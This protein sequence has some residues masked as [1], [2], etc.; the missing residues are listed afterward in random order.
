MAIHNFKTLLES[1]NKKTTL[2]EGEFYGVPGVEFIW[3]GEWS[4]PEVKYKDHLFNYYELENVL[5]DE[6]KEEYPEAREEDFDKYVLENK[7]RVYELLDDMLA[8]SGIEEAISHCLNAHKLKDE[9]SVTL[10]EDTTD[11][12]VP[13]F[14]GCYETP[15]QN[16]VNHL[17]D[18]GKI[19]VD[20][21]NEAVQEKLPSLSY[22]FEKVVSPKAYNFST[23]E[24]Y[25]K[26][27]FDLDEIINFLKNSEDF[28]Q[29]C[30]DNFSSY[31]GFMS[32]VPN[33]AS[34]FINELENGDNGKKNQC[35]QGVVQFII[36]PI[37][38]ELR[39]KLYDEVMGNV[40]EDLVA[41]VLERLEGGEE[42]Y[43]TGNGTSFELNKA[44][45][46]Y[47]EAQA[48]NALK[49]A[50]EKE[51]SHNWE[52]RWLTE[53]DLEDYDPQWFN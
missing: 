7:A 46:S 29:Y 33:S 25:A 12:I 21:V 23:D 34:E 32:F 35:L 47:T 8:N 6:F 24:V 5:W 53:R 13:G 3:H 20:L 11:T 14:P 17:D 51:P 42:L 50:Q 4:D 37:I 39:Y 48:D 45:I 36:H 10:Q 31:D 30:K 19:W 16:Y 26:A 18:C 27:N 15:L 40:E 28:D 49:S 22:S 41:I 52:L 44:D 9:G 38:D 43:W 2:T 1:L